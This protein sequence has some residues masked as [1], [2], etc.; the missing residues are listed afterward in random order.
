MGPG[1]NRDS[2]GSINS[3]GS[4]TARESTRSSVLPWRRKNRVASYTDFDETVERG[5]VYDGS[6]AEADEA[7]KRASGLSLGNQVRLAAGVGPAASVLQAAGGE[8]ARR[9][10]GPAC[11]CSTSVRP[12]HNPAPRPPSLPRCQVLEALQSVGPSLRQASIAEAM[13]DEDKRLSWMNKLMGNVYQL[14]RSDDVN[15]EEE[16]GEGEAGG[17]APAEVFFNPLSAFRWAGAAAAGQGWGC[18]RTH[19]GAF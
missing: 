9:G 11:A 7:A 18:A 10:V 8:A 4:S 5:S 2:S 13:Q 17:E 6:G 1:R 15:G 16:E 14:A 19:L 12:A 3:G